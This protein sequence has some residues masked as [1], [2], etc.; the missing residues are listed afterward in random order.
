MFIYLYHQLRLHLGRKS[1]IF[2]VRG[3][4]NIQ[5]EQDQTEQLRLDIGKQPE[6]IN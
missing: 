3:I 4:G 5:T 6:Q 1:G 2:S